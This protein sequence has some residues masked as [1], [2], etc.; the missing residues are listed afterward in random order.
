MA[1]TA[2]KQLPFFLQ[3][4]VI[5]VSML[6][7]QQLHTTIAERRTDE[8]ADVMMNNIN[9]DATFTVSGSMK[10]RNGSNSNSAKNDL[11]D[12]L[13]SDMNDALNLAIQVKD[14]Y[15][16]IKDQRV[17]AAD[18][19]RRGEADILTLQNKITNVQARLDKNSRI[20]ERCSTRI[21]KANEDLTSIQVQYV[22]LITKADRAITCLKGDCTKASTSISLEV[23]TA[24]TST[25]PEVDIRKGE[26]VT[27]TT[28]ESITTS[29]FLRQTATTSNV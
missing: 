21:K 26:E 25:S 14:H 7:H 3:S 5:L 1:A 12:P 19:I 11:G 17:E 18:I 16:A 27:D 9:E 20:K 6:L 29:T 22:E 23:D 15:K 8:V 4:G 13:E 10:K 24:S 2:L 28:K